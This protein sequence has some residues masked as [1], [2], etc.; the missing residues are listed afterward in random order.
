[1]YLFSVCSIMC[2]CVCMILLFTLAVIIIVNLLHQYCQ[3]YQAQVRQLVSNI[4]VEQI[5]LVTSESKT[6]L[7]PQKYVY[8]LIL[9][10][11]TLC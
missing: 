7:S 5:L 8:Y 9:A 2:V 6:T 11:I 1:M 3:Y 10:I 4:E